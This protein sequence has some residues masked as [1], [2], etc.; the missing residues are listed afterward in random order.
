MQTT[1][2]IEAT[3]QTLADFSMGVTSDEYR[4]LKNLLIVQVVLIVLV[5]FVGLHNCTLLQKIFYR[6]RYFQKIYSLLCG[7]LPAKKAAVCRQE[8]PEDPS[9]LRSKSLST[10]T[11]SDPGSNTTNNK[12]IGQPVQDPNNNDGVLVVGTGRTVPIRNYLGNSNPSGSEAPPLPGAVA[13]PLAPPP[14]PAPPL[15]AA[16]AAAA[17]TAALLADNEN[18]QTSVKTM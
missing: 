12:H 13:P 15:A 14:A 7:L 6:Y 10:E 18:D 5:L 16:A 8:D 4:T 9:P 17:E 2:S 11:R 3:S 1:P